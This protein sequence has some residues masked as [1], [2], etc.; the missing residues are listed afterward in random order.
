MKERI[1]S[2]RQLSLKENIS[3][4][5]THAVIQHLLNQEIVSKRGNHV[6]ISN[7]DKLLNGVGWER[8][9][10]NLNKTEM[11]LSYDNAHEAAKEITYMLTGKEIGF[12]F[13]SYTA[14]GLYTGY[15][16]RHDS[17]Y[18]Y[19]DM[20]NMKFFNEVFKNYGEEGIKVKI[21]GSDRNVFTDNRKMED[22]NVVSPSQ[23][24]LDVAGLGYT[25]RNLA[26][27][28]V[29]RYESL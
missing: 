9:F 23:A 6:E 25:G 1:T 24:L 15:A 21:Y 17:L 20:D 29:K 5:W 10:E 26:V 16:M 22:I 19:L 2:I 11:F 8:P 3:Y 14:G 28:M 27:E 12:A 7:I 18:L 4:G 13:T